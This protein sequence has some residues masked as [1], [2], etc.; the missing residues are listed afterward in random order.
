MIFLT[1]GHH[2]KD[3]GATYNGR[4]EAEETIRLRNSLTKLLTEK[5]VLVWND[6]DDWNLSRT[7]AEISKLSKPFDIICDL[8]FNAG[9]ASA[10]GCEIFVADNADADELIL[11]KELTITIASTLLIRNRGVKKESS[12]QHKRLGIM[13]PIGRNVLIE[14]CFISNNYDMQQYDAFF[15]LLVEEMAR[16]LMSKV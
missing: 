5:G 4:K 16:V 14:I 7:I 10:T 15:D 3:P 13:R 12:S 2:R 6:A 8:H 11:A 9:P 1:A